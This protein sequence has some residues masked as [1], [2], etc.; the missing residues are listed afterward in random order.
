MNLM[1]YIPEL[2]LPDEFNVKNS[3]NNIPW[4][5]EGLYFIFSKRKEIL[6]IGQAACLRKRLRTHFSGSSHVRGSKDFYCFKFK[7]VKLV[8][9]RDIYET[10]YINKLRP[11]YNLAKNDKEVI[12]ETRKQFE[13]EASIQVENVEEYKPSFDENKPMD[14][15]KL[16]YYESL[17]D[18]RGMKTFQ[19]QIGK[20]PDEWNEYISYKMNLM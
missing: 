18:V 20:Y 9:E 13:Q 14:E 12:E 4:N 1:D 16:K 10:Y 3:I 19:N 2:T 6:Y 11:K 15:N 7:E 17:F 5:L 8:F